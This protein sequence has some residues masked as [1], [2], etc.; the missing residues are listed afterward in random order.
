MSTLG[1]TSTFGLEHGATPLRGAP[2][3]LIEA[4]SE[5]AGRACILGHEALVGSVVAGLVIERVVAEGGIGVVYAA[6]EAASDRRFAV[7][8]LQ[9]RHAGDIGIVSR[10][11]REIAYA[12]RVDHPNL[13]SV[14]DHGHLEDGRP[15]FVMELLEGCTLG[16]LIRVG[17]AL[18]LSRALCIGDQILAGLAALHA[19]RI[20]HRDLQPDNV[21]IARGDDGAD[22]VILI[23]LGFAQ[24]PGVDTG[25]GVTPDSPGSLVGTLSFMSPEQAT[26]ARAITE[27][28][29][30]F[31][32]ALLVYYALSGKLPFRGSDELQVVVSI[33]RQAPVP[34]RK[35]R[36][37]VPTEL[38][39]ILLRAF[40]KHPD[41]R[42]RDAGEMRAALAVLAAAK[43]VPARRV[44]SARPTAHAGG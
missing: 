23:D 20:V 13:A 26:R 39:E 33:V 11:E 6:R 10:F 38:D 30:L 27:R 1:A 17:G 37:D 25:D 24:D 40:A 43:P 7:K 34:L 28:S 35:E 12:R 5:A 36:R 3:S 22:R 42:F 16:Q 18:P 31:A 4:L 29:D 2:P 15:F 44:R 32:A 19:A 14:L 21:F 8:V 41:A 9:Q